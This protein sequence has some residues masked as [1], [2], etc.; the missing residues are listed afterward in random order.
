MKFSLESIANAAIIIIC[1]LLLA[2]FVRRHDFFGKGPSQDT[3]SSLTGTTLASLQEYRWSDHD[4]TLVLALQVGCHYCEASMPFYGRLAQLQQSHRIHPNLLALMP[5]ENASGTQVLK[6]FGVDIACACGHPLSSMH[7][8]GTPTLL[9]VNAQG[10]VERVW[11]GQLPS[12]GE[13]EVI[14]ELE[15]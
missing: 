9:L 6:S 11:E 5:D 14:A 8:A 3:A 7:I 12:S 10:R 4:K 1:V 2:Q 13:N 15:K